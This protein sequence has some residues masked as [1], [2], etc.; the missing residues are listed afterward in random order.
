MFIV[1]KIKVQKPIQKSIFP[2]I[3]YTD[4]NILTKLSSSQIKYEEKQTSTKN[5]FSSITDS[6]KNMYNSSSKKIF[7]CKKI[8]FHIDSIDKE[9]GEK[10]SINE[11]NLYNNKK[12][13]FKIYSSRIRKVGIN[14]G[15]WKYDEHMKFIE[16]LNNFGN[17]W[18]KFKKYIGTRS[19]NQIRSHAQ[20][21]FLKLKTFKDISLGIDF[22]VDTVKNFTD[23]I[24]KIKEYEKKNNCD[25]ILAIIN[26]KLLER[27]LKKKNCTIDK[28]NDVLELKY[29]EI[30]KKRVGSNEA[31][32]YID[33]KKLFENNNRN[34][35]II[36]NDNNLKFKNII[37]LEE[38][39][40][41][42]EIKFES[43]LENNIIKIEKNE[44]NQNL[45]DNEKKIFDFINKGINFMVDYEDDNSNE[46]DS[47][48]NDNFLFPFSRYIKEANTFNM[49]NRD[50]FY[51]DLYNI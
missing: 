16:G 42:K 12:I 17:E 18:K 41:R 33:E 51:K 28:I 36:N 34:I 32:N 24:N 46:F 31:I 23:I 5:S 35:N 14:E 26:H 1:Y 48:E 21:F 6:D 30:I 11:T 44:K 19:T 25:N 40:N 9:K 37:S 43:K 15:R 8:K 27:D 49:I 22:T 2:T 4:P 50:Y 39:E 10:N 47:E 45:I 7:L 13:K 38:N 29:N 20:K 3:S